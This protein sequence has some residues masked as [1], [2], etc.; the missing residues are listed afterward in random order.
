LL[1]SN[2]GIYQ[3]IH[4]YL[5]NRK[6]GI[7]YRDKMN[8]I[9]RNQFGENV[10]AAAVKQRDYRKRKQNFEV[11]STNCEKSTPDAIIFALVDQRKKKIQEG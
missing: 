6:H 10:T 5:S 1:I 7:S 2:E 11:L 9:V 4:N 3:E 8:K